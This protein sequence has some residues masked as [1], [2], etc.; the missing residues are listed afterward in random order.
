MSKKDHKFDRLVKG[1]K[2]PVYRT[3]MVG[4]A[5]VTWLTMGGGT[6]KHGKESGSFTMD[7]QGTTL[8]V[9]IDDDKDDM[10]GDY[11]VSVEDLINEVLRAR[12]EK[13][14]LVE[15]PET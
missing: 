7:T 8:I 9:R 2:I 14:P 3:V 11:F 5:T 10:G 15:V 12:R 6:F 13:L 1:A 4:D